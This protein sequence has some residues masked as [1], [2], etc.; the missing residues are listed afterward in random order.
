M[1]VSLLKSWHTYDRLKEEWN[2]W[3]K[4][5]HKYTSSV[6]WWCRHTKQRIRTLFRKIAERIMDFRK[7]DTF[8]HNAIY[9]L[10]SAQIEYQRK[11]TAL[12]E[13]KAKI[14]K[15]HSRQ[16]RSMMLDTG[17]TDC[18][19]KE[20]P[21]LYHLLRMDKRRKQRMIHICTPESE[22]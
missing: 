21:S 14:I 7:M 20:E 3:T 10:L 13:L 16:Y 2:V 15:L 9:D 5:R 11:N 8:Y 12:K 22:I 18:Y 6:E 17:E 19:G 4:I 1:N